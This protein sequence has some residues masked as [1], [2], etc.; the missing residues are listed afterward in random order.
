MCNSNYHYTKV[1]FYEK[2]SA[3]KCTVI[4]SFLTLVYEQE[5]DSRT[6]QV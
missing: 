1:V 4:G 2:L 5:K 3:W 6:A